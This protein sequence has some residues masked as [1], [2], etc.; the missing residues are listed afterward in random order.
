MVCIDFTSGPMMACSTSTTFGWVI[1]WRISGESLCGK[2][3][4][5]TSAISASSP[6]PSAGA[7]PTMSPRSPRTM[8]TVSRRSA[9]TSSALSSPSQAT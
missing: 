9:S 8:A 2:W 4:A 1:A 6:R 3:M 7:L 5:M